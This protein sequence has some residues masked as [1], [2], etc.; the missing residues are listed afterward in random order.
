MRL[1]IT[2]TGNHVHLSRDGE[3]TLCRHRRFGVV[4]DEW[5]SDDLPQKV[6]ERET[7]L[8]QTCRRKAEEEAPDV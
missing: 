1:V 6:C 2:L 4:L 3:R 5:D 7:A 8:C